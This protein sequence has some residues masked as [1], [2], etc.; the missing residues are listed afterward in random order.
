V[1]NLILSPVGYELRQNL[2]NSSF[3]LLVKGIFHRRNYCFSE[4][5][6]D[7]PIDQRAFSLFCILLFRI[8]LLLI[9][10]SHF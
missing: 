10:R 1:K 6:A 8:D 4:S 7:F 9:K 2:Q 5:I 3:W